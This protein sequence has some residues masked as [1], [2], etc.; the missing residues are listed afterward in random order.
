M[1]GVGETSGSSVN[2]C[3]VEFDSPDIAESDL[4]MRYM[5]TDLPTLV[6]F[7]RGELITDTK[8]VDVDKLKDEGYLMEWIANEAKRNG[9][10]TGGGT[11][12]GLFGGLLGYNQQ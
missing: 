8:V 10:G 4:A 6:A 5:I 1:H 3:E 12:G 9:Q 2:Y 11:S 7:D